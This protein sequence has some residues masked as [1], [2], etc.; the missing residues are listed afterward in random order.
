MCYVSLEQK[1]NLFGQDFF[2]EWTQEAGYYYMVDQWSQDV[3]KGE[4]LWENHV[5]PTIPNYQYSVYDE[6]NLLPAIEQGSL[7]INFIE[8]VLV[9][10]I[11]DIR[12]D[13]PKRSTSMENDMI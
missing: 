9:T 8:Q 7:Q 12:N 4:A 13:C 1:K 10:K 6:Q 5:K 3:K 2:D 11:Y